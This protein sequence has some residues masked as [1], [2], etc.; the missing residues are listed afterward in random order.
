MSIRRYAENFKIQIDFYLEEKIQFILQSIDAISF[1]T[2]CIETNDFWIVLKIFKTE[3]FREN[4]M[5]KKWIC[6]GV[7]DGE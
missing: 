1:M 4:G 3:F 2:E 6:T 5:L 7:R